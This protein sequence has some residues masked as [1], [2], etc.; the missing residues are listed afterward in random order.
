MVP[1]VVIA[2]PQGQL[3]GSW[4]PVPMRVSVMWLLLHQS[5]FH[6]IP[7][8]CGSFIE[9]GSDQMA[10]NMVSVDLN[11]AIL[12]HINITSNSDFCLSND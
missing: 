5:L 8:H 6:F 1:G 4:V 2:L 12:L 10:V 7:K 3:V 9:L 11:G